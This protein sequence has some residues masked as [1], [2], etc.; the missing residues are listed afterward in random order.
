ME[1][2]VNPLET[3]LNHL[4]QHGKRNNLVLSGILDAV[5]NKDLESTVSSILSDIDVTVDRPH[6]VETCQRIGFSGKVQ[7]TTS[8]D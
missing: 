3:K 8:L 1:K 7:K 2:K 4:D 6:D 5:E